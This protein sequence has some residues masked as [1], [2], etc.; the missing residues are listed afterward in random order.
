MVDDGYRYATRSD[1]KDKRTQ[2]FSYWRLSGCCARPEW[3]RAFRTI[4]RRKAPLFRSTN[5]DFFQ[6]SGTRI[7][8]S[9]WA[10]RKIKD[11]TQL[12]SSKYSYIFTWHRF[13]CEPWVRKQRVA[14]TSFLQGTSA[15][16]RLFVNAVF[17]SVRA[18]SE[19]V[20]LSKWTE[21]E[22][23]LMMSNSRAGGCSRLIVHQRRMHLWKK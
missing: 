23:G 7:T 10:G 17:P 22:F 16:G 20:T 15:R 14:K 1:Q 2:A 9:T 8:V 6:K 13:F 18:A 12:K 3:G 19:T 5:P 4:V 11:S 21:G